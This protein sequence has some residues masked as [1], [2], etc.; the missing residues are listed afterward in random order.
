MTTEN[1]KPADKVR[2]AI[3]Q[4]YTQA[5]PSVVTL[6]TKNNNF[7]ATVK[8]FGAEQYA[9]WEEK[10]AFDHQAVDAERRLL[11]NAARD[12]KTMLD[13]VNSLDGGEAKNWATTP[14]AEVKSRYA[15]SDP[16]TQDVVTTGYAINRMNQELEKSGVTHGGDVA[17]YSSLCEKVN[18]HYIKLQKDVAANPNDP[19]KKE[20]LEK[21]KATLNDCRECGLN[22]GVADKA[23]EPTAQISETLKAS[24]LS[25]FKTGKL[26]GDA[27]ELSE[28]GK[29][30]NVKL[31]DNL[32][33]L[34]IAERSGSGAVGP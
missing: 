15:G 21:F 1:L 31:G 29:F 7:I 3:N 5:P 22:F 9:K 33:A 2:A 6:K 20:K 26:K 13:V 32:L 18:T 19:S 8:Q 17:S 23:L 28:Q 11:G 14:L 4:L 16:G 10:T 34:A 30:L 12:D 24:L 25:D 27:A